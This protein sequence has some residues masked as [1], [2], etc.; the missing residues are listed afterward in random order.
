MTTE[1]HQRAAG[2][3]AGVA[4][5]KTPGWITR[6]CGGSDLHG[7]SALHVCKLKDEQRIEEEKEGGQSPLT[8]G[9][10]IKTR[11]NRRTDG[12]PPLKDGRVE[13]KIFI[14]AKYFY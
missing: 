3:R 6:F 13:E 10:G 1:R 12:K 8:D 4:N 5:S 11:W 2:D 7:E 14:S 9:S